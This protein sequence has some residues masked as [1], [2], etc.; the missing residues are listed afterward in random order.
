MQSW[1]SYWDAPNKSYVNERHKRAHYDVLF[2]GVR[3]FVPTAPGSVVLDWG[4][5]DALAAERIADLCGGTVLLYDPANSTRERLRRLHGTHPRIRVLDDAAMS[6]VAPDTV[7][8]V[9][10]NS[11]IQYLQE[12]QLAGALTLFHRVLRPGG[13]LLLGDVIAPGTPTLRHVTTFLKFA[14]TRGFLLPAAIGLASTYVS[15]YRRLQRDVGLAAYAPDQMIAMLRRH[16]FVA[17]QLPRNIAVSPHRS[18]YVA[19]K[20]STP[21]RSVG[22]RSVSSQDERAKT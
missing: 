21:D 14:S 20:A 12:Q 7:D 10:V 9:V 15:P 1:L 6:S 11:V 22:S 5:G 2:D 3:R 8:L 19:R 18:A 13:A 16:A 17:D 4:C